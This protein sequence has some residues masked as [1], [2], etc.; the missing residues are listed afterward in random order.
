MIIFCF[1]SNCITIANT[2]SIF[3]KPVEAQ[4]CAYTAPVEEVVEEEAPVEET[5]EEVEEEQSGFAGITG[6]VLGLFGSEVNFSNLGL[7][8]GIS[9]FVMVYA[10]KNSTKKKK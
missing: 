7:L 4:D 2:W 9:L 1:D 6:A 8:L 10:R 3:D 5:V